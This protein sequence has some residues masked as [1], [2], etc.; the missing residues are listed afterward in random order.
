MK[1]QNIPD[2]SNVKHVKTL[3][4]IE[5]CY[6][7]LRAC[8]YEVGSELTSKTGDIE[9]AIWRNPQTGLAFMMLT[10][11][12][13]VELILDPE[14]EA[15]SDRAVFREI[16]VEGVFAPDE[17]GNLVARYTLSLDVLLP[18]IRDHLDDTQLLRCVRSKP[19]VDWS[20]LERGYFTN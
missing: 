5:Y 1:N 19:C 17:D 7:R 6:S 16:V 14:P 15:E 20:W 18:A 2:A 10:T 13:G 3:L 8:G 11:E 4:I 9:D 12:E